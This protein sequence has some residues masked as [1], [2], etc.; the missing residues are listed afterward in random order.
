MMGLEQSLP[1]YVKKV[2]ASLWPNKKG[3][4]MSEHSITLTLPDAVYRQAQRVA[5][6]TQQAI[7]EVVLTWIHPAPE[8]VLMG[9]NELS[10]DELFAVAQTTV[11]PVRIR[12]L[13]DLLAAQRQRNLTEIEEQEAAQLV[14]QE[15]L[16]TLRKSKAL[17]LLKQRGALTKDLHA[18]GV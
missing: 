15:D 14:E 8:E 3:K 6:T 17:L 9:L 7:E 12:R 10:N 18:S 1:L 5:K 13:Q 4:P 11:S 16:L 2:R